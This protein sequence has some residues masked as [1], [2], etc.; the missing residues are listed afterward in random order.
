MPQMLRKITLESRMKTLEQEVAALKRRAD[1]GDWVNRLTG[2]MQNEP[3]FEKVIDLGREARR[4]DRPASRK[5][6]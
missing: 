2:S 3:E 1:H 5:R 6:R 4:S